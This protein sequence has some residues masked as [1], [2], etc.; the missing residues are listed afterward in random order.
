MALSLR[1]ENESSLPDGGPLGVTVTGKRGIDI[2]RD[3]HLDWTLPDPTRY[4]S[5]KHC[6]IRYEDGAYWLYDAS[7]NGTYLYG[8]DDRLKGPHCL[9][10]GDRLVIG[11]YVI[12]VAIDGDEA[13]R[14]ARSSRPAKA[15]TRPLGA[16]AKAAQ[17]ARADAKAATR[18]LGADAKA[19]EEAAKARLGAKVAAKVF[20]SYRREDSAGYAGRIH[21]RLELEF[22]RDNLFMDVDSIPLGLNFVKILRGEVAKCGVLLAVMGP[23]WCDVCDEDG[24]RRLDNSKD[25]VRIEI[26]TALQRDIPVI[27]ILLDGAKVPK[28]DR[29]PKELGELGERNG[30]EVGHAS[31]HIDMD[32][33]IRKLRTLLNLGRSDPDAEGR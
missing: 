16:D 2:G 3:Q 22:G 29:L 14:V 1:I 20:I 17:Q 15:A 5:G 31:F 11:H 19:A 10:H 13:R 8:S 27:P 26:A 25:F 30:F 24:N 7:T 33:L 18:P 21:D 9:H 23:K 4:I 28:A 6:E 12:A 32:V